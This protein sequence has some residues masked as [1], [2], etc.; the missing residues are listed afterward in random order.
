MV[1]HLPSDFKRQIADIYFVWA[2]RRYYCYY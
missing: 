1:K 2:D